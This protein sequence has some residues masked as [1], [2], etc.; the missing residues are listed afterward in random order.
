MKEKPS[1]G[2]EEVVG[3]GDDF[4]D[5]EEGEEDAEF[6]DFDDGFQEAGPPVQAQPTPAFAYVRSSIPTLIHISNQ[7]I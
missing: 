1:D 5:F 7:L 2:V 3:F 6:D 4:D